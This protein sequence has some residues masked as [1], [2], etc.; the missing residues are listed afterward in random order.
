MAVIYYKIFAS[1]T[2]EHIQGAQ[3]GWLNNLYK[4][5]MSA[6]EQC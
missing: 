2:C 3:W 5:K 4:S 1:K 6:N